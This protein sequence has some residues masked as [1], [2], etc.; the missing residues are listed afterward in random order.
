MKLFFYILTACVIFASGCKTTYDGS[1]LAEFADGDFTKPEITAFPGSGWVS[2]KIVLPQENLTEPEFSRVISRPSQEQ[3]R[4]Y[5]IFYDFSSSK[6]QPKA[7]SKKRFSENIKVANKGGAGVFSFAL[8]ETALKTHK[9]LF[10]ASD[11]LGSTSNLMCLGGN[12]GPL[13]LHAC[14]LQISDHLVGSTEFAS[15]IESP[16]PYSS[17]DYIQDCTKKFGSVETFDCSQQ[18]TGSLSLTN[19]DKSNKAYY[20]CDKKAGDLASIV[21]LNE[22]TQNFCW[23]K[24]RINLLTINN[25]QRFEIADGEV[26]NGAHLA[27]VTEKS[28]T[29]DNKAKEILSVK[30]NVEMTHDDFKDVMV[31]LVHVSRKNQETKMLLY[32]GTNED[33]QDS[34]AVKTIQNLMKSHFSAVNTP[35][36]KRI[37]GQFPAGTWSLKFEDSTKLRVGLV[38]KASIE[39]LSMP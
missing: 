13:V 14:M 6:N 12:Q 10:R 39:F 11:F 17:S 27:G 3:E 24:A 37:I 34:K 7:C 18:T 29:A 16:S 25:G 32:D 36:L 26:S 23:Y 9:C 19:P 2:G 35:E 15:K 33:S 30:V 5:K 38:K 31:W 20:F 28:I 22:K 1:P 21:L 8:N 4:H